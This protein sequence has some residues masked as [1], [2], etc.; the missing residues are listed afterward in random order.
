MIDSFLKYIQ[1]EKRFSPHTVSS[2]RNDLT[3]AEHFLLTE[4][5]SKLHEA[6]YH[7]LRSW[8]INLVEQGLEGKTVNRKVASLKSYYK[9]L[10]RRQVIE[11]SPAEKLKPLKSPK[12]LPSFVR[13]SEM[14]N[15]L[16]VIPFSE[17]FFGQRDKLILSFLYGTGIRL[18]ELINLQESDINLYQNN[19]KVL[20]K[21]NK[22]RVVP[23][24]QS[25]TA[26]VEKY[27]TLKKECFPENFC[28][29]LIVTDQGRKSY[30]MMVYRVV[31]EYLSMVTGSEKKSPHVLRHT[32]ATHLLNKGADLNAV[33]DLLGHASLAATQVYTHN[34]LDKLKAVYKQA[35]PKA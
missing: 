15:L 13:E 33:K 7:A 10:L 20:G 27:L 19:V 2:Y 31:K 1:F 35:H 5:S 29:F 11:K 9:F 23:L 34:T 28:T 12:L 22:E 3:Q 30:P 14:I 24:P 21:R 8:V 17:D 4:F 32:F 26:E 18:S 25:L 6:N 16:D